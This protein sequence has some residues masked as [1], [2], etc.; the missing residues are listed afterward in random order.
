MFKLKLLGGP[1]LCFRFLKLEGGDW[2]FGGI[3]RLRIWGL[4]V[5]LV[6]Y[7]DIFAYILIFIVADTL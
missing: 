3:L 1:C 2:L 7:G 5:Q 4:G 6:A